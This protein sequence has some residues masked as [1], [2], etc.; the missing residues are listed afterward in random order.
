MKGLLGGL[1]DEVGATVRKVGLTYE[2]DGSKVGG[3]I[4]EG[5]NYAFTLVLRNTFVYNSVGLPEKKGR[6]GD[7]VEDIESIAILCKQF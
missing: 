5:V 2:L 7:F 3:S 1:C 6:A 4:W